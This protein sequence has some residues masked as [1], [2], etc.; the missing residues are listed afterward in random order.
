[1]KHYAYLYF[2]MSVGGDEEWSDQLVLQL[3]AKNN[4][5]ITCKKQGRF[6]VNANKIIRTYN[7]K[8]KV[9]MP[10]IYNE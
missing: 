1:M 9:E 10:G 4:G 3:D 5:D 6:K 8:E 7:P 2:S